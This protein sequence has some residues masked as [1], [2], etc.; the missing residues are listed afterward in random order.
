MRSTARAIIF[1]FARFRKKNEKVSF[2]IGIVYFRKSEESTDR[3]YFV[4]IKR[5]KKKYVDT[6]IIF[7]IIMSIKITEG[8]SHL[9]KRKAIE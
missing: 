8:I 9:D 2:L 5:I 6:P 7:V 1:W 3:N 4:I